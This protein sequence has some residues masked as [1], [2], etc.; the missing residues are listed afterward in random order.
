MTEPR[1]RER[2]EDVD[3]HFY[4]QVRRTAR[5]ERQLVEGNQEHYGWRHGEF[6]ESGYPIPQHTPVI[7]RV[8]H[9]LGV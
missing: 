1:T 4:E 6:D 7:E 8:R 3:P 2:R 9:L 5:F